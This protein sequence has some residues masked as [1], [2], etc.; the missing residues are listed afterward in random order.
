MQWLKIKQVVRDER[1]NRND[2][3][4]NLTLKNCGRLKLYFQNLPLCR[5]QVF[6]ARKAAHGIHQKIVF[7]DEDQGQIMH[8]KWVNAEII[9]HRHCIYRRYTD[10]DQNWVGQVSVSLVLGIKV[11]S[12]TDQIACDVS[13]TNTNSNCYLTFRF[14]FVFRGTK[15]RAIVFKTCVHV[16]YNM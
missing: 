14:V 9:T 5:K 10:I 15:S 16:V 1:T 3:F 12:E 4:L 6:K 7:E 2:C 8:S 11:G 13:N